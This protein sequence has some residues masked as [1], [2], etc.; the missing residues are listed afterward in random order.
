M[1]AHGW[2]QAWMA[3][4]PQGS[5]REKG[6][7]GHLAQLPGAMKMELGHTENAFNLLMHLGL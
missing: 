3:L 5:F 4:L 2:P 6:A 7:F 1:S